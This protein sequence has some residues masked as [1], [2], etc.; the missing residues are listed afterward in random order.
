MGDGVARV[1]GFDV[2]RVESVVESVVVRVLLALVV[3]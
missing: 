3:Q 2:E 1:I